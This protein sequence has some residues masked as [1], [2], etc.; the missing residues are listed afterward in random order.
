VSLT[1]RRITD[2]L[3]VLASQGALSIVAVIAVAIAAA[4]IGDNLGYWTAHE[5]WTRAARPLPADPSLRRTT[6]VLIR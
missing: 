3:R 5:G 6:Q 4:I 2:R 1:Q